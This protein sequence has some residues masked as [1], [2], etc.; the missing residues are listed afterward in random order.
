MKKLF[1]LAFILICSFAFSQITFSVTTQATSCSGLSDG[2]ATI[3]ATGGTAPYSYTLSSAPSPT[4][5]TG[6]FSGLAAGAQTVSVS[7][8]LATTNYTTIIITSPIPITP[9][10]TSTP[11]LCFGTATGTINVIG[12]SGG[13]SPFQYNLNGGAYQSS[14]TFLNVSSGTL[15]VGV[16]DANGCIGSNTV[17]VIEP[18]A[19][20]MS[21]ST[22]NANCSV[23]NGVAS[24]TVTGGTGILTYSWTPIS[25]AAS[26]S[27]NLAAGNYTVT[28]TDANGCS[29]SNNVTINSTPGGTAVI[30]SSS[31]VTCNGLCDGSLTAGLVGGTGPF[32]YSW[33]P[34]GQTIPTA[35]NLC[36]GTY[37]CAI[38]DFYGCISSTTATISQPSPFNIIVNSN[39]VRCFGTT[40]GTITAAGVG[41]TSPY[42]YLWPTLTSTMATVPNVVAGTYSVIGTDANGCSITQ[43]VSVFQPT[44]ILA[45]TTVTNATCNGACDGAFNIVTTGGSAPYTFSSNIG[46]CMALNTSQCPGTQTISITDA[47]NCLFQLAVTITQPSSITVIMTATNSNCG[48]ANGALCATFSGGQSPYNSLWSNGATTLCNNNIPAGAY[49]YTVTDSNGCSGI[50]SGLVND[51]GGP[52]VS[53]ASQTN[54]LC[55]GGSNGGA[56]TNVVGG[57]SPYTYA[58]TISGNQSS[59]T[60]MPAGM[61]GVSITDAAGCVGTQSV[62]ISQPQQLIA[63]ISNFNNTCFG[64]CNGSASVVSTGGVG[65]VNYTW[66]TAPSQSGQTINNICP[67]NWICIVTDANG[68]TA[69]SSVTITQPPAVTVSVTYTN[70]TCSAG[71]C[72]GIGS[73]SVLG[74]TGATTFLWQ[75]GLQTGSVVNTLCSG[76]NTV[77]VT[78]NGNCVYTETISITNQST[79]PIPNVTLSSTSF[80]ETCLQTGDGAIDLSITGSNPG[81]FTYQWNNGA[82]TQD[83]I[84]INSGIY[85]VTILDAMMNC[86]TITDTVSFDNSNC[87]SISGNVFI[88]NNSDCVKNA[89]D[90]NLSNTQIIANPGNRL[91]YTN[92]LGDYAFYNLPFGTYT[93]TSITSSNMIAT[94]VNTNNTTLNSGSPNSINNNFTREYIPV[95]QPDLYVSASNGGVVP[96]FVCTVYYYLNNYNTFNASGVYKVTLPSAFIPNITQV[97]ASTYTISGDTVIW[98]FSNVTMSPNSSYFFIKFTTPLSTPLGSIFTTC[99]WAQP[100]VTDLNYANNTYCYSRTVNGS[101]DPNDKTVSPVGY[102]PNGDIAASETDLTYLI[103]FQNTGNGP[104]VNIVVKDTLSPNVDVTTFE[105]LSASHNY[106]IDILPGNVLRWKFNNIM[107]ADSGSNEP[108]SHGYIQYRIKRNSNNTPGTQIKNTAYIYFDFNEPVVTNTA[109]NTIETV[110]SIKSQ[111]FNENGWNVYPNP[112]T[113]ALYII[114]STNVKEES[115]IEVIN[116]IGQTVFEESI[117]SNYKNIDLN[118]LTNGVYFVKIT[119][120]KNSTVKR[121]VL[122]K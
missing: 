20:T 35:T 2:S 65:F 87:G 97:S 75:P 18:P 31:N 48:Q 119:S 9:T 43:S 33:S 112:C 62:L 54:V 56:T 25:G 15:L 116:S 49:S 32:T 72:N 98:N 99:M 21:V 91:A 58:W 10:V 103:R 22:Q 85:S 59:I 67:G 19:L 115:K 95:I 111:S 107:L 38:T 110:T 122:S 5:T 23:A 64:A 12:V 71:F 117:S 1:S 34:S 8:A 53:I 63:T 3:T 16:K 46:P 73:V 42:S 45:T 96:G 77:M 81:P 78:N 89:G 108:A 39:N 92:W 36:P 109:I 120:D 74:G 4:N 40:T 29:I 100:T 88:D 101:F 69:T 83:L 114:N 86:V 37:T 50:S 118:K 57:V 80:S 44:Q 13:I 93:I 52:I 41:G 121:V 70:A 102:G 28:A 51:I 55:F 47:N 61:Y 105:M 26:T 17:Q 90:N 84:N 82:T 79:N 24:T 66:N 11:V 106:N 113:G 94:C 104:A 6:I 27:N 60:N 14:S 68:C 76:V 30:T 7:D